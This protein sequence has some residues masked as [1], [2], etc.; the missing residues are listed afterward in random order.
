MYGS[1]RTWSLYG[2]WDNI[3]SILHGRAGLARIG[4]ISA[5]LRTPHLHSPLCF[6]A[7]SQ[8]V[9]HNSSTQTPSDEPNHS[10]ISCGGA[11]NNIY[12]Q[13]SRLS[14]QEFIRHVPADVQLTTSPSNPLL[15]HQLL[16][17]DEQ[18]NSRD[19]RFGQ[20]WSI[21]NTLPPQPRARSTKYRSQP[22][23][24]T[25]PKRPHHQNRPNI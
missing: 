21:H 18:T 5:E 16:S 7:N 20:S 3:A 19:R 25:F 14:R 6:L 9:H 8:T 11:N 10:A 22:T 17:S 1:R 23:N 12:L 13:S 15:L 24:S 2:L 4:M